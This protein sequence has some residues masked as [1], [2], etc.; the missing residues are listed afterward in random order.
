[1]EKMGQL[2]AEEKKEEETG[3]SLFHQL[4][5]QRKDLGEESKTVLQRLVV[6]ARLP[7]RRDDGTQLGAHY[8]NLN[9][10]LSKRYIWD[11]ITGLMLI[12]PSC[13]LHVIESSR[14]ILISILKDLTVMQQ[15]PHCTLLEA[16][17]VF[18]AHNPQ[19]RLFQQW[20]YKVLTANQAAG[21]KRLQ[22][23][24]ETDTLLCIV[25]SA[26]QDLG[27][28]LE[29]SKKALPESVL[30][31]TPELIVPQKIL[32]KLLTRG[33]LLSPQQHLQ[34]YA[35]PLNVSIESGQVNLRNFCPTA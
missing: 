23:D 19:S 26:L 25:L 10:Q 18:M 24:D 17:I 32:D 7:S 28:C 8:E 5:A 9:F 29:I 27:K 6:V 22:E 16:K 11:H 1:M 20:S 21:I 3:T 4:L 14:D 31:E 35:S 12:Y 34:M 2:N 30:D 15:Q 13:L 33:E